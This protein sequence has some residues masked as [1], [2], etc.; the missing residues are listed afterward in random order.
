MTTE[1][2][3]DVTCVWPLAATLGEGPVWSVPDQCLWFVDIKRHQLHRHVPGTEGGQTWALP[4]QAGFALPATGGELVIGLPGE[5]RAFDPRNG[6]SRPLLSFEQDRPGNRLNDAHVDAAGRLWFGSMDDAE[7]A[8]SGALYA[9]VQGRLTRHDDGICITNGPVTSPDGR[10]LY[11]TDTVRREI[12]AFDLAAD[13]TTSAKRLFLRFDG[14]HGWPDGSSVDAEGCLWVAFFGGWGVRR[15]APDGRLLAVVPLPCANVTKL[16]FGGP[17]LR[18]AYV[19][20]AR[21][22]LSEAELAAQPLAGGLFSFTAPAPGLP[23]TAWD[24]PA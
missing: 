15:Y 23:S 3:T 13:G 4:G 12:H 9:C 14:S 18:T 21:K 11:H 6:Q 16:A 5:L 7:T 20:T 1:P 17:D 24:L 22:G 2:S 10:T 19:T 8:L